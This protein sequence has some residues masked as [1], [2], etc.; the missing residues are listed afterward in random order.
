MHLLPSHHDRSHLDQFIEIVLM[1]LPI[2]G[3]LASGFGIISKLYHGKCWH[4]HEHTSQELFITAST[5]DKYC[6]NLILWIHIPLVFSFF[7]E[8]SIASYLRCHIALFKGV[9]FIH[10]RTYGKKHEVEGTL[11]CQVSKQKGEIHGSCL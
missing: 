4:L 5:I 10:V 2:I 8:S 1:Y 11:K 6:P 7:I 9:S 3:E